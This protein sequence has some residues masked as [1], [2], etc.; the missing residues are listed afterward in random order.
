MIGGPGRSGRSTALLS[1][2]AS[3]LTRQ[4]QVIVFAPRNSPLRSLAGTPGV[5]EVFTGA[6][7]SAEEFTAALAQATGPVLIAADDA[8]AC[9]TLG[10]TGTTRGA[11][12]RRGEGRGHGLGR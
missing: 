9:G 6:D 3:Y 5:I 7:V 8:E 4:E 2:V 1:M 11:Q 12:E 10:L